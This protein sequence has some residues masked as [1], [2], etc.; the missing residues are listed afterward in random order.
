MITQKVLEEVCDKILTMDRKIRFVEIIFKNKKYSKTRKGLKS[1]LTSPET[2]VSIADSL[3]R[4]ETRK[5]L[6]HKLG[7]PLYAFAEYEKVKRLTIPI[8]HEGLILV[9]LDSFGFHEVILKEIIEIKEG[10]SWDLY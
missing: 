2:E 10:I 8:N 1:I 5:K 7:Q 6:A 3:L 4:W 9:S